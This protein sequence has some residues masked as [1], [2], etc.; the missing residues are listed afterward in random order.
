[1]IVPQHTRH[2]CLR[3]APSLLSPLSTRVASRASVPGQRSWAAN[4][5]TIELPTPL[6]QLPPCTTLFKACVVCLSQQCTV[7]THSV[8]SPSS[9]HTSH[10]EPPSP[11]AC[12]AGPTG[13]EG[14][15][16]KAPRNS[17]QLRGDVRDMRSFIHTSASPYSLACECMC[18]HNSSNNSVSNKTLHCPKGGDCSWWW[19]W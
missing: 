13:V 10:T 2:G 5:S 17:A 18:A 14:V 8:N 12:P 6:P 4:N 3:A 15:S 11:A 19:W 9:T 16:K 1:M 7:L